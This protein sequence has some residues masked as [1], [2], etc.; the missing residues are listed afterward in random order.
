[1]G[2]PR[3]TLII[4]LT[5]V[6]T[7]AWRDIFSN[8]QTSPSTVLSTRHPSVIRMLIIA[9]VNRIG[10]KSVISRHCMVCS[11]ESVP[12]LAQPGRTGSEGPP[13]HRRGALSCERLSFALRSRSAREI[14]L[15][16]DR[17]QRTVPLHFRERVVDLPD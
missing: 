2:R 7:D 17:I 11:S 1:M 14:P 12:T 4:A 6:T 3:T 5:A 10:T 8:A 16:Q 15:L 13:V 9:P